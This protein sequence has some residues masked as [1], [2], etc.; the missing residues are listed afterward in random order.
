M[1]PQALRWLRLGQVL[2]AL[3]LAL[4]TAVLLL[5]IG[6]GSQWSWRPSGAAPL[7]FPL[8]CAAALLVAGIGV[9][10][11]L[12][13]Y[14]LADTG[15]RRGLLG[16]SW[17]L[18]LGATA[19]VT[20]F[21]LYG[22]VE[23]GWTT[24][25]DS[26]ASPVSCEY[27]GEGL[28]LAEGDFGG[29]I[30]YCRGYGERQR[31]SGHHL[32]T[33][34]PGATLFYA[35]AIGAARATGLDRVA[36]DAA[37][38]LTG[39]SRL[40]LAGRM[41][42][43]GGTERASI[44]DVGLPL[45]AALAIALF[46]G[47]CVWPAAG[48]AREI[49]GEEAEFPAACLAA[50]T[51]ALLLHFQNLDVPLAWLTLMAGWMTL[52]SAR[53]GGWSLVAGAALGLGCFV[54]FGVLAGVGLCLLV[55]LLAPGA[56]RREPGLARWARAGGVLFG[57]VALWGLLA[58]VLGADPVGYARAAGEAHREVIETFGR[59]YRVW[60]WMNLVEFGCFLGPPLV[61]LAFAGGLRALREGGAAR[62]W[63]IAAC[64]LLLALDLSGTV[65]AEVGRIWL[66]LML[67]MAVLAAGAG[68]PER[69]GYAH[70]WLSA[71]L[72]TALL[73]AGLAVALAAGLHPVVRPF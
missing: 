52:A 8:G 4:W 64:A 30:A 33:H 12:S 46:G 11:V 72:P 14:T 37:A 62:A 15:L 3:L 40:A 29:V 10:W 36:A 48:C 25:L 45:V 57:L 69:A 35:A 73:Q 71:W 54:S 1:S 19:T 42:A 13:S 34:P 70:R 26:A 68:M 63:A 50:T 22:S 51:P 44:E 58:V 28:G 17:R 16:L 32:A 56:E 31:E 59:E 7:L 61:L 9:S 20:P 67:P 53:R 41:G 49:W 60:V 55:A 5:P 39:S 23:R 66:F 21:L 38:R 43:A 47:L 65:R 24:L 2:S 6:W 18:A 27:F